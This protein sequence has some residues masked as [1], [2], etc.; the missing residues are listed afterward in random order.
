VATLKPES[1]AAL[2]VLSGG[3]VSPSD[4]PF[5]K[6]C[7]GPLTAQSGQSFLKIQV[8]DDIDIGHELSHRYAGGSPSAAFI[9]VRDSSNVKPL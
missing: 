4:A 9:P 7:A 2:V 5:F 1:A 6:T 3:A 8:C